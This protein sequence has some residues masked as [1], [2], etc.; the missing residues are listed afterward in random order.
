MKILKLAMKN[1][2][3]WIILYCI[4]STISIIIMAIVW[5]NQECTKFDKAPLEKELI[6]SELKIKEYENKI[7]TDSLIIWNSSRS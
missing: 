5:S 2:V 6:K 3:F 1:P 4:L 7:K